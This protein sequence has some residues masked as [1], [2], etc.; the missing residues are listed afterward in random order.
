[1]GYEDNHGRADQAHGLP[2]LLSFDDTFQA[3]DMEWIFKDEPGSFETDL[4]LSEIAPV[5]ILIPGESH[6][7][8]CIIACTKKY[9]QCESEMPRLV[10]A[11][12]RK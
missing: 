3:A 11:R 4:V 6:D 2:T 10:A 12:R 5:L 1:M 8:R 9:V 7:R